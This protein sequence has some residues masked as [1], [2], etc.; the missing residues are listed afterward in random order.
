[1]NGWRK[2]KDAT[3]TQDI[4]SRGVGNV[5]TFSTGF[6]RPSFSMSKEEAKKHQERAFRREN[7]DTTTMKLSARSSS[8][9]TIDNS[10][11]RHISSLISSLNRILNPHLVEGIRSLYLFRDGRRK[12]I[13]FGDIS[14]LSNADEAT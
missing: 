1:M 3:S 13:S 12:V 7:F 14:A 10:E 8:A 11:L 2:K 6:L 5:V 9:A 4:T